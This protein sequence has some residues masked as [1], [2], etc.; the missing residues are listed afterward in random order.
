MQFFLKIAISA[1]LIAGISE[2]GKRFTTIAAIL[3]SLP[4]LSILAMVWLY[5]DTKSNA[6]V[7]A[8]S[9]SIFWMVLPSLTFFLVFPALLKTKLTFYP[10]LAISMCIMFVTYT[11]YIFVLNKLGI[12]L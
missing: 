5:V 12:Q 8:L 6:K 3:A 1:I 2:L 9:Y 7:M 10:A 11:I 4:L